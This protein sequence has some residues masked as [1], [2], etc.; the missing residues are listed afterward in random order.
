MSLLYDNVQDV[1]QTHVLIIGVGAY[2]N[3]PGGTDP[4]EQQFFSAQSLGQLTTSILSAKA[5]Y[6][7]VLELGREKSAGERVG[8]WTKPLGSV[9]VLISQ[10]PGTNPI[11]EQPINPANRANIL[12]AYFSWKNRCNTRADNV[13]VFYFCGHG[14]DKGEHFLLAQD[15]GKVPENPWEGSFAFDM[16]R[17]AFFG[18]KAETQLF[19]IDACRQLTSDMIM[20]DVPLNPIE[21]PSLRAR[22]CKFNL[23]QKAAAANESAY[24]PKSGVTFYTQALIGALTGNA[25]D[26]DNSQW[27]VNTGTLAARMNA[28]LQRVAPSEGY[29]QRCIS[30]TS[31]VVDIIHFDHPPVVQVTIGCLP[32]KA[33]AHAHL[34]CEN[35]QTNNEHTRE[36]EALP[37]KVVVEAGIYRL[38][39]SF[40]GGEFQSTSVVKPI[41]P[42]FVNQQI[43]CVQ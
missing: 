20:I 27:R 3:L 30:T 12:Q 23:T 15:F 2:D 10:V 25:S 19:F 9:E 5:F 4:K 13:A 32:D 18:C 38:K 16:T 39:A 34:A 22:D 42:P 26:N 36:P 41:A 11:F 6:E 35:L 31:D 1:A 29:S 40:T 37:W 28:F 17:R 33:L 43:N 7:T 14:L 24:G 8:N 21:P